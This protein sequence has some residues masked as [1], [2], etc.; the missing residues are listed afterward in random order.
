M[1]SRWMG[2]RQWLSGSELRLCPDNPTLQPI[3]DCIVIKNLCAFIQ[4]P[5]HTLPLPTSCSSSTSPSSGFS[6]TRSYTSRKS[7][8]WSKR[9]ALFRTSRNDLL[10]H[11]DKWVCNMCQWSSRVPRLWTRDNMFLDFYRRCLLRVARYILK[12]NGFSDYL[13]AS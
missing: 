9:R 5:L 3:R 2:T 10:W 11:G 7:D 13:I 12:H 4:L 1:W 8:R 6:F